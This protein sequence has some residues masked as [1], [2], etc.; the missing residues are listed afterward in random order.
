MLRTH[1]ACLAAICFL[2]FFPAFATEQRLISIV[3]PGHEYK[4]ALSSLLKKLKPITVTINDPVY[5]KQKSFDGFPLRDVLGAAG[6]REWSAD[7]IVFTASDGYSPNAPFAWLEKYGAVL[8][9]QEHGKKGYE[10][11]LQGKT[12]LSPLPFYLVWTS[13][14]PIPEGAPWPYQLVKI[15]FVDFQ[16]KFDRIYPKGQASDSAV[17]SGF[18]IFKSECIRCHSLNLQGGELGP[19]LN[20]P[21]NITEYWQKDILRKFIRNAS[22]FRHRDKMPPFPQ[23]SDADLDNLISYLEYM[24]EHKVAP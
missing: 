4:I 7:E 15:E 11:I 1:A 22:A 10:T 21:M 19:E 13:E 9:F 20:A 16:K 6:I 23:L 18:K 24:K 2:N 12:T 5:K 3:V 8:T 14:A 17:F